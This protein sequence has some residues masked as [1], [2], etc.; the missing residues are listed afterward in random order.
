MDTIDLCTSIDRWETSHSTERG[1]IDAL[2]A[3][4]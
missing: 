1:D 2:F 3:L 4:F